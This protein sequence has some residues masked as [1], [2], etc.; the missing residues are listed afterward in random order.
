MSYE[1]ASK[2]DLEAQKLIEE[3]IRVTS[4][5]RTDEMTLGRLEKRARKLIG[6]NAQAAHTCLGAIGALRFDAKRVNEHFKIALR[7]PG[8][9][10]TV[11][12]NYSVALQ[13]VEDLQGSF[14]AIQGALQLDPGNPTY[15]DMAVRRALDAGRFREAAKY[16]ERYDAARPVEKPNELGHTAQELVDALSEETFTEGGVRNLL[17]IAAKVQRKHRVQRE[18]VRIS[19]ETDDPHSFSVR[20]SVWT[21]PKHAAE[22]N[23]ELADVWAADEALS[24]D[25]GF[26]LTVSFVGMETPGVS[27][28][29]GD[30]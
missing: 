15:L 4:D 1:L 21:T 11:H 25:P 28:P 10:S 6:G 17:E 8:D 12:V 3:L 22:M 24:G 26:K 14:A 20:K 19:C 30:P 2:A 27:D 7:L 5:G 18:S 23:E 16:A 29:Q 9:R 13:H